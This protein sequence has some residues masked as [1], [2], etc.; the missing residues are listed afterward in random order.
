MAELINLRTARKNKQRDEAE[1]LADEN[2]LKFG[3]S[4]I[5]KK[6]TAALN[7]LA[8]KRLDGNKRES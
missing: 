5:E 7:A 3:R 4:K 6:T 8:E 1:K 2:R